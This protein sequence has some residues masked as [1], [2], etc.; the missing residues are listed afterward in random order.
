MV[1]DSVTVLPSKAGIN[2]TITK[3]SSHPMLTWPHWAAAV[4]HYAVYRGATAPYFAPDTGT[5]QADVPAPSGTPPI[6]VTFPDP[7]VDLSVAGTSSFYVVTPMNASGAPIGS[8]N[9]T[10]A[11]VYG[12]TPGN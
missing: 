11:F 3:P 8:S 6:D 10:G 5:W 1:A 2:V 4:K 12:L 9:R 7:E